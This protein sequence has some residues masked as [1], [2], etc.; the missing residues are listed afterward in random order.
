MQIV[1]VSWDITADVALTEDLTR[2]KALTEAR[3]TELEAAKGAHRI[4]FAA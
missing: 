4:Q 2:S 3:N 1:G